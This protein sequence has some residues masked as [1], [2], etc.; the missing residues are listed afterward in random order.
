MSTQVQIRRGNT[1]QT[2]AFTG[3]V[4]EI[5]VDTDKKT[6]VVHDGSTA[7]GFA[8]ARES[9]VTSNAAFSQASFNTANAAFLQAN[10]PSYVAN[11]AAIY[12]N[13]AFAAANTASLSTGAYAQ[14]NA[15][16]NT[17]NASFTVANNALTSS[18]GSIIW[19]T[20]NA[21]F[22]KANTPDY[23]A[24]SAAIYA[25]GAFTAA[26]TA[27]SKATSAGSYANAAFAAAN[28]ASLS[29]GAYAQ[30]NAAFTRA[31][32]SL[33]ANT[34]GTVVGDVSITGNLTVTGAT[35]YTNTTTV[36]IADNIITVNA[37]INQSAQPAV[38]AGIE[39]DRG[40]Q[41]N[42]SFLWIE[43][44]N[45]WAAN[46]GNGSIFIAADSAETYANSAFVRANNA[47]NANNGGT[48][49]GN[50]VISANLTASN[51]AS[52]TYIQFGD[53]TKQYTANSTV[54]TPANVSISSYSV[55]ANG[56]QTVFNIGFS[57]S[58]PET[59]FVTIDG[60]V[61]PPSSYTTNSSANTI[62][63][64]ATPANGEQVG[65]VSFYTSVSPYVIPDAS[66]T[67]AKF[68]SNATTYIEQTA[69]DAAV[70]LAIA[71]G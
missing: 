66:I 37:A 4:A 70:S 47:L 10:T 23:V 1:T 60:V 8:L 24:N 26:N 63:L 35:T 33:N 34:G 50:V 2:G 29:T 49:T 55:T 31:N 18:N 67:K 40:A 38:N 20:A 25:N 71:L 16:F 69:A 21:A 14:A 13:A 62:T 28:T 43:T 44:S 17:A 11:S 42:S 36:L 3:V 52:Q 15:A 41:P 7:G 27:D 39:V 61:Q 54:I 22:L 32:N 5:T 58:A 65:V 68:S 59:I 46:N 56:A 19:A 45:K 53:G 51:V 57:P 12:A 48:I 6:V 64:D 9:A 30:A